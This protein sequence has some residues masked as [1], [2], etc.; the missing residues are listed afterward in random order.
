MSRVDTPNPIGSYDS[1][2]IVSSVVSSPEA[3]RDM[4]S[5]SSQPGN[6]K[7]PAS[8]R[9]LHR[10][11]TV[12]KEQS[13]SLTRIAGRL[14]IDIA[15]ARRQEIET[16]DLSLSQFY[17]WRNVLEVPAGE[18]IVEAD[19]I[20]NNPI[21]SRSQ[22]IKMM[23]TVRSMQEH[24]KEENILILANQL[25]DLM[26]EL[27]PEL[28][29]VSAWPSIGQAREQRDPGQAALRRFDANISRRLED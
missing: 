9:P 23:K 20:P 12:R 19:E 6:L 15:E 21:R 28:K 29:S 3:I 5:A 18:L 22:L 4:V 25:S 10:I 26:I 7:A 17:R 11:A 14:G 13:I 1:D 8:N 16:T 2:Q 24:A 27:M